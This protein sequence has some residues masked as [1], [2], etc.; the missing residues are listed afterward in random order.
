MA[1]QASPP[2]WTNLK[3]GDCISL[4]SQGGR[5]Y[6][7]SEGF[8][9]RRLFV[10][11][12]EDSHDCPEDFGGCVFRI[13]PKNQ[14]RQEKKLRKWMKSKGLLE[15]RTF[16]LE[17]AR[18]GDTK[19]LDPEDRK[20]MERLVDSFETEIRLNE[21]EYGRLCGTEVRYGD[22]IQLLHLKSN[23][24]VIMK[25]SEV[26]ELETNFLRIHLDET[27]SES[28]W[29]KISPRY[30]AVEE[31]ES[32][33]MET[34]VSLIY[35][36]TGVESLHCSEALFDEGHPLEGKHEVNG[37]GDGDK[38]WRVMPYAEYSDTRNKYLFGGD[39][40]RLYQKEE[41][42]WLS[43]APKVAQF[44]SD[45]FGKPSHTMKSQSTNTLWIVERERRNVGGV[46]TFSDHVRLRH[47]G[48]GA[49]L[50]LAGKPREYPSEVQN[51]HV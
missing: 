48:T 14:Y 34:A 31:G 17:L 3:I 49:T 41:E 44:E 42:V 21:A 46:L 25:K 38:G 4:Y 28:T 10:D 19:N 50:T 8:T 40:V 30:R 6:L 11:A 32:V 33:R 23:K 7:Q 2:T 37:S 15:G 51:L 9:D 18:S 1:V 29:F 39:V 47:F 26:S 22:T 27:G 20:M 36:K 16:S 45:V 12:L 13:C 35:A 5:G 24:F 43:T